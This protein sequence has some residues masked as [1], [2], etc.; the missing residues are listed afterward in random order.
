MCLP[1][2][3]P[4][5]QRRTFFLTSQRQSCC[6]ASAPAAD[7]A[8]VARARRL[9]RFL[10]QPFFTTGSFTGTK[11]AWV[12]IADTLDGCETILGQDHFDDNETDYYM[13]GALREKVATP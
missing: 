7:R 6:R 12:S 9:E 3:L 2:T 4:T 13:I 11:G 1:M 5:R 10:T 8:T